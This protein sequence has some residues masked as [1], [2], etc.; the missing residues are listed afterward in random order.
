MLNEEEKE[1][2]GR[3]RIEKKKTN[4]EESKIMKMENEEET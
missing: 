3:K 4:E 1:D 2:R